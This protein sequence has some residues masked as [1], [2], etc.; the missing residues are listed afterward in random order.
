[1]HEKYFANPQNILQHNLIAPRN[2]TYLICKY[3]IKEIRHKADLLRLKVNERI[4]YK[5]IRKVNE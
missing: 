5:K 3:M 4:H 1:M 2:T